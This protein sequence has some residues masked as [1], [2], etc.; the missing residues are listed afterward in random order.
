MSHNPMGLR[1]LFAC[2]RDSFTF[3]YNSVPDEHGIFR[4]QSSSAC[5]SIMPERYLYS[6]CIEYCSV[7]VFL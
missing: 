2:Y 6:V 3:I 5:D 4:I 7:K 1:F